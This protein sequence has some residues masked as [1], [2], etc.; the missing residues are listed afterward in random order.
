MSQPFLRNMS[1]GA[2]LSCSTFAL[3]GSVFLIF[4][5]FIGHSAS[6]MAKA[7]AL[8]EVAD[9]TKMLADTVEIVD[10]DLR[11]QVA[12]F[13]K[14]FKS[15]FKDEFALDAGRVAEIGGTRAPALR[16][17]ATELNGDF[18]I[19]DRFTALTGVYATVFARSGDDFVRVTTSHKKESGE[20]AVGTVLDHAHPAYAL[21]L[22]GKSYAG[23][24]ALFGGQYMTQYDPITDAGGKVIGI[25]YV[26]VNFTESMKSLAEGVRAMRLGDTGLFY[27]LSTKPGKDYGKAMIHAKLENQ[28][29]LDTKDRDG[30]E[31]V[32]EMLDK[33][34]GDLRYQGEDGG[35]ARERIVAFSYS[36]SWN[37][38]V[39]GDVYLDEVTAAAIRQRNQAALIG[40]L[41][42]IGM[43]ALVYPLIRNMVGRPLA[44]ALKV[45]ETVAAGDLTSRIEVHSND[46]TGRLMGAM[47]Q[48]NESLVRI[49]GEVRQ[50][51]DTIVSAAGQIAAGNLDLSSR[52]EQQASSLEET[53]SS[54]EQLMST[55]KQNGDN[56]RQ[57]NVLAAS[58]SDVASK[59]GEV[60]AHVVETMDSINASSKKI[61]DIIGVIDGIAFQ[62]N[63]LA[64]NAAV[65]AARAGEQGR[66][67]AVVATEVRNLAQRSAA[68]AKEIKALIGDSVEQVEAGSKLVGQAGATMDEIVASVKRVTDI[69][70]EI[71]SA[72]SEQEAG[73]GQINEAI[74]QMDVATQQ[75]AALVEEAAAASGSLHDQADNLAQVVQVFKLDGVRE[76]A[77]ARLAQ[78]APAPRAAKPAALGIGASNSGRF[79]PARKSAGAEQEWETF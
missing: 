42:V 30:R 37:M 54:I 51:T 16:S 6:E 43:A 41:I 9:K 4:I 76:I 44:R 14:I 23:A 36:K 13:A 49:V 78:A 52:T 60:V 17:G 72:S 61:V 18:T 33:K 19:P 45:A 50:G 79:A 40:L 10:K 67:F 2:K 69:M 25:L 70:G 71:T 1:I 3:V 53:A 55:V 65:E 27:A 15:N 20:R 32:K 34:N 68:A 77:G 7:N 38:L 58:A 73:I 56:A 48:M 31:Y 74:N 22:A 11:N 39:V 62:T 29:L 46:E 59:G 35:R 63:I 28:N 66:G 75:N 12:T 5:L 64:L 8:R 24:A 47:K 21:I 26:G 57:A